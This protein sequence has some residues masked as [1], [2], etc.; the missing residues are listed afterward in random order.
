MQ[1]NESP[2]EGGWEQPNPPDHP[3]QE[4]IALGYGG[5]PNDVDRGG[6][7]EDGYAP[8]GYGR[9]G[10][11]GCGGSPTAGMAAG[12]APPATAG[13]APPVTAGP[14]PPATAG[15]APPATAGPARPATAGPAPRLQ[16]IRHGQLRR[17]RPCRV[18]AGRAHTPAAALPEAAPAH[19]PLRHRRRARRGPR[20]RG[21]RRVRHPGRGRGL[22][23]RLRGG[24]GMAGAARPGN[25]VGS[26]LPLA[27][28]ASAMAATIRPFSPACRSRR[29][30]TP[31]RCSAR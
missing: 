21:D 29:W 15:P 20:G 19:A 25:R 2:G 17:V 24:L 13:P 18:G 1:E 26:Y 7:G 6:F 3:D 10:T 23:P 9:Y 4:T 5:Y 8:T 16:P 11:A 28:I 30:P 27:H 31:R 22:L 12:P 14:A